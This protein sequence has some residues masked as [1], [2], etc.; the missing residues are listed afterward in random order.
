M[1]EY[2][3]FI[4]ENIAPYQAEKIGVYKDGVKI[5]E[6]ELS[7]LKQ[8]FGTRLYR[9]GLISDVHN[10]S[11]QTTENTADLQRALNLF[12]NKESVAFTCICGDI[13][14]NGTEAEFQIY[15]NNVSTF[16]PNTPVYTTTG[17]HDCTSSGLNTTAWSTYTG[18]DEVFEISKSYTDASGATKTDH[19]LFLGMHTWSLGPSGTPYLDTTIT[20]ITDKLEEYKADRCFVFTHLFFPDRAGNVNEVYGSTL[21]LGGSQLNSLEAL[22]QKYPNVI[23]FSGHSHWK[24]SMQSYE[25][26]ANIQRDENRLYPESAWAVHVPSCAEPRILGSGGTTRQDCPLESEGAIVDVYENYIDIRGINLKDN[27]YLPIA[28]YRLD[29]SIQP[30]CPPAKI[31]T[32]GLWELGRWGTTDGIDEDWGSD[33]NPIRTAGYIPISRDNRYFITTIGPI[34]GP[35]ED[36]KGVRELSIGLFDSSYNYLGRSKGFTLTTKPGSTNEDVVYFD[37]IYDRVEITDLLFG[38]Y[39]TTPAY[40]RLKCYGCNSIFKITPEHGEKFVILEQ[41]GT[42]GSTGGDTSEAPYLTAANF[43]IMSGSPTVTDL[44][45]NYVQIKFTAKDQKFYV[46]AQGYSSSVEQYGMY[47]CEDV[48]AIAKNGIDYTSQ[49]KTIKFGWWHPDA[50]LGLTGSLQLD[51][52]GKE[53]PQFNMSSTASLPVSSTKFFPL[54]ITLKAR[55][56]FVNK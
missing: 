47:E 15:A 41:I 23:W 53:K 52:S 44:A 28:Q 19:F 7:G 54:T 21:W 6:I 37:D 29:T 38:S 13:T 12:N 10:Q 8:D 1:A 55:M 50:Y 48:T 18:H 36:D 30:L 56:K 34:G 16:S 27:L 9:F 22:F 24:W 51:A 39:S 5:S 31:I 35:R 33:L 46:D 26:D 25:S 3:D 20:W 32:D 49:A 2:K 40:M 14:Q 17:N 42:G 43:S 45:D 11:S 4:K